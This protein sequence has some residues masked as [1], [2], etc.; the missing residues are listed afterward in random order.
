MQTVFC[1]I[2]DLKHLNSKVIFAILECDELRFACLG[3]LLLTTD[4]KRSV[5]GNVKLKDFFAAFVSI[6]YGRIQAVKTFSGAKRL[7]QVWG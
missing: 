6:F 5:F 3:Q 1:E 2:L 4:F 7:Q